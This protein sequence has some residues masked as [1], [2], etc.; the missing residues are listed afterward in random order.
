MLDSLEEIFRLGTMATGI[1]GERVLLNSHTPME[2]GLFIQ[3]IYDTIK[4]ERSL[5]IG[6]AMGISTMFIL[7]KCREYKR[8]N[9]CH[10]VIEP[11]SWGPAAMFNITKEGLDK[12]VDLRNELSDRILP[13][14][15][16]DNERI[17]MAY[18]DTTKV[19]DTVLQDFYFID[20]ILD[21]G[22][23]III[24]DAT[25]G[26]VGTVVRFINTLPHY[27][28]MERF[29][30]VQL[31]GK[32]K[33][34]QKLLELTLKLMPFRNKFKR[35]FLLKSAAQLELDYRCIAFKKLK[36]DSRPW[37]WYKPF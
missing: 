26:G 33:L 21:V 31:S 3:K 20:K 15:Y 35:Q 30:K 10:I 5:E 23:V 29:Q 4:P 11:Y 22:G 9:K 17:Q 19:F 36:N 18:V 14:M 12:Y 16:L 1:E 2:Q 25:C 28:V 24:D 34:E 8:N 13:Q 37:D 27:Q 7:E 6:F 32:V